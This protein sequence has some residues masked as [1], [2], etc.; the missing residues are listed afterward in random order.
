MSPFATADM[1]PE[2]VLKPEDDPNSRFTTRE[3]MAWVKETCALELGLPSP[4]FEFDLD[5]FAHPEAHWGTEWWTKADNAYTRWLAERNYVNGPWDECGKVVSWIREQLP[6]NFRH[7]FTAQILPDNR[8]EQEWWQELIE[9]I[10]D[11]RERKGIVV[12]THSPPRRLEYGF[13]G[14]PN[15]V[16]QGQMNVCSVLLIWRTR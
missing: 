11:R 5:P 7:T 13:P 3:T 4:D 2:A 8:R 12:T 16:N 15:G 10:R 14:N 9:P 6:R 1:F